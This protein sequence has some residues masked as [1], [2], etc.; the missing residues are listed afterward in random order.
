MSV[1][2]ATLPVLRSAA[3]AAEIRAFVLTHAWSL[4][5]VGVLAAGGALRLV[6][7]GSVGFNSDE[8][9]YAGQAASVAGDPGYVPYFPIF[10]AHP[11][12]F[13]T[14]LS[15]LYL[16]GVG[17]VEGR[18]LGALFGVA[19]IGVVYLTGSLL[20]GRPVGVLAAALMAVM[21]YHVVVTRQVLLDGP[22]TFFA[23][24][25][26]YLVARY[27][28]TQRPAWLYAAG[29]A[30]GLTFLSKETGVL[31]LGSVYAFFALSRH[32]HL[33]VRDLGLAFAAFLAVAI[34]YPMSLVF[35]GK[36]STGSNFLAWQVFRRPNHGFAFYVTHVPTALGLVVVLLV[37]V[38][39]VVLWHDRSWRETL[40]WSWIA[41]PVVVFELWSVKGFQYLLPIAPA[42]AILAAK[43]CLA[44]PRNAPVPEVYRRRVGAAL[45]VLTLASLAV[46]TWSRIH[47]GRDGTFLA[48]SGG[49]PGGRETGQWVAKNVPRGS[50]LLA[51]GPSMANIVKFYGHRQ[52]FGLSVS[53]NPLHRNPAY[54]PVG[55]PDLQIR[56]NK[57]QYLVWDSF[58]AGRS[59]Y[60][61]GQL[62]R[63]VE[64]YHG[65]AVHTE[66]VQVG[67]VARPVVIVYEVRP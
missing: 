26:L 28:V 16:D 64:R 41:V 22:M 7:L 58:S 40:L 36:G 3:T 2:A 11:M 17:D 65:R 6:G 8:A 67:T 48:G 18:V 23:T 61:A 30:L 19:T 59:P 34:P 21:P 32:V 33:R 43:C 49:V 37:L 12:L 13:Q 42:V 54:T 60:F 15:L 10:R 4:G 50:T 45:V 44:L 57:L 25:T 51:L 38:G 24:V 14:L 55:N 47:P 52:T 53:S 27:S 5:L 63:Y 46:P 35:S 9:V 31:L 62:M 20:Y 39:A 66:T 29:G 1:Q 56:T